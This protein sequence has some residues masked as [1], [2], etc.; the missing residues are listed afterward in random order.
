MTTKYFSDLTPRK[1]ISKFPPLSV[2]Q[3]D[4][5]EKPSTA[6][7]ELETSPAC[8]YFTHEDGK[9]TGRT[10]TRST[11][12]TLTR[13][14]AS[15]THLNTTNDNGIIWE[16]KERIDSFNI[17]YESLRQADKTIEGYTNLTEL[18][19]SNS[20]DVYKTMKSQFPDLAQVFSMANDTIFK[21]LR[22]VLE[23]CNEERCKVRMVVEEVNEKRREVF[24]KYEKLGQGYTELLRIKK[25]DELDIDA[26][27]IKIFPD[28]SEEVNAFKERVIQMRDIRPE[29]TLQVL[30][31]VYNDLSRERSMPEDP[32]ADYSGMDP[33]SVTQGIRSNYQVIVNKTIK[34]VKKG[35][36]SSCVKYNRSVQT[37]GVYIDPKAFEELNKIVEKAQASQISTG[38]QLDRLR[39]DLKNTQTSLE[40][41]ESE[42]S[43]LRVELIGTRKDLE[44]RIKD[45]ASLRQEIENKKAEILVLNRIFNDKNKDF[46]RL[47]TKLRIAEHEKNEL[48][49]MGTGVEVGR[50]LSEVEAGGYKE[51]KNKPIEEIK[52][53]GSGLDAVTKS[54]LTVREELERQYV[55]QFPKLAPKGHEATG[56]EL[57]S[58]EE[59]VV[60]TSP[61]VLQSTTEYLG[62]NSP[63][64]TSDDP[65]ETKEL[66]D[67][68]DTRKEKKKL[69]VN[70]SMSISVQRQG[71]KQKKPKKAEKIEKHS[72]PSISVQIQPKSKLKISKNSDFSFIKIQ[73]ESSISQLTVNSPSNRCESKTK[74]MNTEGETLEPSTENQNALK[75]LSVKTANKASGSGSVLDIKAG[76]SIGIQTNEDSQKKHEEETPMLKFHSINPNNL[77]GLRGDVF[78]QGCQFIPQPKMPELAYPSKNF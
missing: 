29:G 10:T 30:K 57:S 41:A 76:V 65:K 53:K 12:Y 58:K 1:D 69:K 11:K 7:Q 47:D 9:L 20:V 28:T 72:N 42:K 32:V 60:N 45:I 55:R 2:K 70:D 23:F 48:K 54:G 13:R 16:L 52:E 36:R 21:L 25:L 31:D 49:R 67:L 44:N 3:K 4:Y 50:V 14:K 5:F 40:H 74:S 6:C 56:H 19:C 51:R 75:S 35:M 17:R 27:L 71:K 39:G 43:S 59:P 73:E 66:S 8:R 77:F 22:E 37:D 68:K 63:L 62:P 26:E 78:Y 46:E 18:C 34:N 38:Q 33:D 24:E 61:G 64:F 15:S